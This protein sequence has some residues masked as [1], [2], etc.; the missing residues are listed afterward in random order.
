MLSL[1][2]ADSRLARRSRRVEQRWLRSL[3]AASTSPIDWHSQPAVSFGAQGQRA[4]EAI[5][6]MFDALRVPRWGGWSIARLSA[7]ASL[8]G[9]AGCAVAASVALHAYATHDEAFWT[10]HIAKLTQSPIYGSDGTLVGSVD[11]RGLLDPR[12]APNRAFIPLSGRIPTVYEAAI[13]FL[14]NRNF[15]TEGVHNI[16]GLDLPSTAWRVISSGFRDGGST[17]SQQLAKELLGYGAEGNALMR[18]WRKFKE[19]GASCR[20]YRYLDR[21]GGRDAVLRL[22]ASYAGT[23]QGNGTLRG[24]EA[25]ARVWFDADPANLSS[26]RQLLLAAAARKPIPLLKDGDLEIPCGQVWPRIDNPS[27][28]TEIAE[29]HPARLIQCQIIARAEVAARA[30]L[31]AG[32]AAAVLASL[33]TFRE[34]GIHPVNPFVPI[35]A[36]KLINLSTRA[37]ASLQPGL[38]AQIQ[39][40]AEKRD[41]PPGMPIRLSF[42]STLEHR[43]T[44]AMRKGLED[45]Q[46]SSAG[47]RVLCMPLLRRAE[48]NPAPV[49][50]TCGN[51]PADTVAADTLAVKVDVGTGSI[52]A[53]Y[54]SSPFLA[55]T[56]MSLGSINKWII[57][58]AALADGHTHRSLLCPRIAMDGARAL[59]RVTKPVTGYAD[60]SN[61]RH[62][63]TVEEALATSDN[64]AFYDL[65]RG[66]GPPKLGQAARW[67]A[68]GDPSTSRD[69]SYDLAFGTYGGT[70][71]EL[72]RAMQALV[73]IAYETDVT[74]IAP[75]VLVGAEP[76]TSAVVQALR[77]ALPLGSQRES[78]RRA[79]EAPVSWS[80]GTLA[81]MS[82]YAV[83]GGKSG[84][85]ESPVT[86]SDGHRFTHAKWA[87]THQ[88]Q[89]GEI[90]LFV[91]TS[92]EPAKPLARHTLDGQVFHR[93]HRILVSPPR[94][95]P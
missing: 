20:L 7:A 65:A 48:G 1:T 29:R 14:E 33:G 43:F 22:Y 25:G 6:A 87:V 85:T 45:I 28:S 49:F 59:R 72:L 37:T 12:D 5:L 60:C 52:K 80:R 42:D 40:E 2:V 82:G 77:A 75:R 51:D 56:P 41:F 57:V 71:S 13:V 15:G 27:Y 44:L 11:T 83:T 84:T 19:I 34:S 93:A 9:V 4:H 23:A 8:A 58:V 66:L 79:L 78:L 76:T 67:L 62:T 88:R 30:V 47:Q 91:V 16:C 50:P 73:A 89:R 26:A 21:Q 3:L 10:D 64:L 53:L 55:N 86:S 63:I 68:I 46:R 61:G 74:G 95:R 38:L 32:N 18:V 17:I 69:L 36:A 92:P 90:N 54:A 31:P 81:F 39:R 35:P 94:E 70:P 24:I